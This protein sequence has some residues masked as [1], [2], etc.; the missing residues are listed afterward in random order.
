MSNTTQLHRSE[1]A[2]TL[3]LLRPETAVALAR[4]ADGRLS[5]LPS[6]ADGV[7]AELVLPPLY[8]ERLGDPAFCT[9]HGCRFP[10]IVGEMARGIA[11]P[12]MVVAAQRAG[13]CGFFGSAGLPVDEIDA[14]L[15]RI[16]GQ[17]GPAAPG[18]GSNLIHA[19][20]SPEEERAVVDLYLRRG[21]A[22]VSASAFM[23]LSPDIV[24]YAANGLARDA[25]G[26]VR[27]RTHIFA[28]VSRAEV[29]R[30][31]MAPAPEAMLRDLVARGAITEA[32]AELAARLPVACDIT[33]EADSGGHTDNRPAAALF[34]SLLR[35]R[36][37]TAAEYGFSPDQIRIGLAG[38][39][40]TPHGVAAAFAMGAAYVLTGSLNQAAVESGLSEDAKTLLVA[41]GPADIAM[42]PAADMFEQGVKVQVLKRGTL[43]AMRGSRLYAIYK[44]RQDFADCSEEEIAFIERVLGETV[45]DAWAATRAW[46]A[47]AQPEDLARTDADPRRQMALV[48]RRYLFSG[49]QWAREGHSDRRSDYQIWCGPAMGAFN[50]WV[51]GSELEPLEARSVAQIGWNLLQGAVQLTRAQQLRALGV[52]VPPSDFEVRPQVFPTAQSEAA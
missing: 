49:A 11:T 41:A 1:R 21:V 2:R 3:A 37:D 13:F 12:D 6:G 4:E 38:G 48:F 31:F 51:K 45:E 26:Q 23:A 35:A 10:Y 30:Q 43:F 39:I 14:G 33:A 47:K 24:R 29:A 25:T 19:P 7:S 32:Q 22:R 36:A 44:T 16:S 27:R 50:E 20:Q 40:A 46:L 34:A 17:L 28:K 8:A 9:L 52:A 18:W 15:A 42:A 5:V